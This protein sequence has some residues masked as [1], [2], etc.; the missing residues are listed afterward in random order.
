MDVFCNENNQLIDGWTAADFE[1]WMK[2]IATTATSHTQLQSLNHADLA[3][4]ISNVRLLLDVDESMLPNDNNNSNNSN[5]SNDSSNTHQQAYIDDEDETKATHLQAISELDYHEQQLENRTLLQRKK[6]IRRTS[7]R[8]EERKKLKSSNFLRQISMFSK[9]DATQFSAVV[10][11]MEYIEFQDDQLVLL[12]GTEANEFCVLTKGAVEIFVKNDNNDTMTN[13]VGRKSA[14]WYFGEKALVKR[15]GGGSIPTRTATIRTRGPCRML[16]L[17][18]DT[19]MKLQQEG[20]VHGEDI[21][22]EMLAREKHWA[23]IHAERQQQTE[24]DY[25][26]Y[27]KHSTL[28]IENNTNGVDLD[29]RQVEKKETHVDVDLTRVVGGDSAADSA[30]AMIMND[31]IE[32]V[33]LLIAHE[34]IHEHHEKRLSI[35]IDQRQAMAG[36]KL[37]LRR[38]ARNILRKS[39]LFSGFTMAVVTKIVKQMEMRKF[40]IGTRVCIQGDEGKEIFEFCVYMVFLWCVVLVV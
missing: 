4:F 14:P 20:V 6:S 30:A 1:E 26:T 28:E 3:S 22:E 5:D 37:I 38:K 18:Y 23:N 11:A 19:F 13:S 17:S 7:I 35:S 39:K 9:M 40:P 8:V 2:M 15:V 31:S 27:E 36:G 16:A 21:E 32:S 10:N 34:A 24:T 29:T 12:Q 33:D 25:D